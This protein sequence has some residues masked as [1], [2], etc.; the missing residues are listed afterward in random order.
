MSYGLA[1]SVIERMCGVFSH[2]PQIEQA[3]L[4]GSRAKGNYRQGSDIDLTLIGGSD[5]SSAVLTKVMNEL[6]DLLL[7]YAID[8]SL[9]RNISDT[10][11][12]DH[13]RRIG[14]VLYKKNGNNDG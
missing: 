11:V 4:Y 10:A 5:L 9:L 12:L 6:D 8:L 3:T 2:Y 14:V 13:I 7:P 1:E